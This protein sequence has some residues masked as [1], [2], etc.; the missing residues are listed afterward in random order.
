M[1][2]AV[3]C[4]LCAL[5]AYAVRPAVPPAAA[6]LHGRGDRGG[7]D[8]ASSPNLPMGAATLLAALRQ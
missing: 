7:D 2:H 1:L 6:S 8:H 3:C 4:V 5:P